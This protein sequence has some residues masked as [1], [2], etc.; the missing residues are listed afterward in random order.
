MLR[1]ADGGVLAE[2]GGRRIY[3]GR[4]ARYSD[5]NR[6]TG[7][8]RQPGSTFKPIVYFAAF[9]SG[10]E[11][12]SQVPDAPIGVELGRG[13]GVKW[14]TNYD[15]KFK[16]PIP[17]RMALAESRNAVAIWLARGV[18]MSHV[19]DAARELGIET[20]L[21]PYVT[22][23]LGA[24]EVR[25]LELAN[26]YRAL[27][28]GIVTNAHVV[29]RVV[30]ASGGLV[31]QAQRS[32]H[33]VPYGSLVQIQEGLRGVI[34]LPDGTAHALDDP[35]FAIPVMGKTGT[36]SD[37][38]DALFVGSTYGADG[39]TVAVRIGFDDDRPLG[40]KETGARVALPVFRQVM[41]QAYAN[42]QLGPVPV[43]P[44]EIEDDISAYLT[45]RDTGVVAMDGPSGLDDGFPGSPARTLHGRARVG[46]V[47]KPQQLLVSWP[48]HE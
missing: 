27:A 10:L 4:V 33:E 32:T 22:T 3:A 18:G 39:I 12:G 38:R 15:D 16:G 9:E 19:L 40:E 2:A 20:P 8:L 48:H 17:I 31:Y 23:A 25:L 28:S 5:L 34:R 1:N 47:A 42:A 30:D 35:D 7:S 6:V 44:R 13:R 14:I 45:V 24:S 29:E 26:L 21:Q 37:F 41:Q 43:F 46:N 36:T 11:L